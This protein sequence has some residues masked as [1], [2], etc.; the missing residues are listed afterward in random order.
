MEYLKATIE[1]VT[2]AN[3]ENGFCVLKVRSAGVPDLVT[4]VGRL[5][6]ANAGASAEFYGEWTVDARYGRQ[7]T[8]SSYRETVPSTLAGIEK[9]LGSGLIKGVGPVNARRIV[10]H[11]R[12][13]TLDIIEDAPHR[14]NEVPGIGEKRVGMITK[15]WQ[16]HREI[17]NVMLFLQQYGVSTTYAIKIYREYGNQSIQN[18]RDNPYRLADDI[19]GI[20]FVTADKIAKQ[21]GMPHDSEMRCRAGLV[22]VLNG[23]SDEGHCYAESAELLQKSQDILEVGAALCE[24]SLAALTGEGRV[25]REE[26]DKYYLPPFY[27]SE[28]GVARRIAEITGIKPGV[29][30]AADAVSAAN[31]ADEAD[32]D[33]AARVDSGARGAGDGYAGGDVAGKAGAASAASAADSMDTADA[34]LLARIDEGIRW[35]EAASGVRYDGVQKEAVRAA[36]TNRFMVLTG[37]P[38]TG[39]TTTTSAII[40]VCERLGARVLLAAPTGRAAKRMSETTGREAKTIHRLLELK[41]PDGYKRDQ[42]N[43]LNCDVLIIDE[44]SMLDIILT[45][46]LLK[47]V[48]AGASVVFVGDVDQLPSVGPGSVLRDIIDSRAIRVVELNRIFRQ[49]QSSDIIKNAHLVNAGKYPIIT[50]DAGTDFF[51]IKKDE[52]PDVVNA[53]KELCSARLPKYLGVNAIEDIQVLSPMTRSET[54]TAQLNAA[55]QELL[56]PNDEKIKFGS[57]TYKLGDKVMQIRNNYDKNVFNGDIGR[58][59][60]ID[61]EDRTLLIRFD[62]TDVEYDV[63][64]LDEVALA[65]AVT[66]HKSQGSEYPVVVCPV[67]TQHYMMLQKNLIYTA[68]TRAK[69]MLV[70]VGSEKALRIALRNKKSAERKTLLSKRLRAH[71]GLDGEQAAPSKKKRRPRAKK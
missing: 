63:S 68:I 49:A 61:S 9:Y 32:A 11:F 17:K 69:R 14:L 65:Y 55:L 1:R 36:L 7:F 67:T 45:Y 66:V 38:G 16:E 29:G 56:N 42:D 46:N 51:F 20:G 6:G 47:A 52:P 5:A 23:F 59:S 3:E 37:G 40:H 53:I 48:P 22:Y 24:A 30:G 31:A 10:R 71:M 12:E 58:I 19:W 34:T 21:M 26:E 44:A 33:G 15:A 54:G 2:F 18:V 4:V 50:N 8:A 62:G 70:L 35:T 60:S 27:H 57:A 28:A 41:P 39:K 13:K 64:E 25:I 43:P